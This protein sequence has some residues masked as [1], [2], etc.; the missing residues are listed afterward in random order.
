MASA[1]THICKWMLGLTVLASAGYGCAEKEP[2]PAPERA[3][4][5]PGYTDV[6]VRLKVRNP[7]AAYLTS[8]AAASA[9][10]PGAKTRSII[11]KGEG[12]YDL[13]FTA[14][15]HMI[16]SLTLIMMD[17]RPDGSEVFDFAQTVPTSDTDDIIPATFDLRG[18]KGIKRFYV[19]ANMT[20]LHIGAFT[21]NGTMIDLGDADD[22]H[23][24]AGRLMTVDHTSGEGSNILMTGTVSG[25]NGQ[26]DFDITELGDQFEMSMADDAI[27][28][29]VETPVSLTKAVSKVL[30]TCS[31]NSQDGKDFVNITDVKDQETGTDTYTGWLHLE[32]VR[33]ILNTLNLKTFAIYQEKTD[34]A[35]AY[36][37]DPNL[38]MGEMVEKRISTADGSWTYGPKNLENYLDNFVYYNTQSMVEM[39]TW[40]QEEDGSGTETYMDCR[41]RTATK[42]DE[43][44][45][46]VDSGNHYTEGLFCPEN[47]VHKDI[48]FTDEDE[49]SAANRLVSTHLVIGGKYV[50]KSIYILENEGQNDETLVL[51]TSSA[52]E[53]SAGLLKSDLNEDLGVT[54]EDGTFWYEIN[55]HEYYTYKAMEWKTRN[56]TKAVFARHDGGWGYW[57]SMIDGEKNA[58]D[59]ISNM[60]QEYWGLKRNH[61]Y[62]VNVKKIITPGASDPGN[63]AM[64]IH[65]ELIDWIDQGGEDID[66][67]VPQN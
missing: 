10:T 52:E 44:R 16:H 2:A 40:E 31:V 47:M 4:Q 20:Q 59:M 56:D 42:Y 46:G 67:T 61:Y 3:Q 35:G 38:D 53:E 33:Y 34:A 63:A 21:E 54:Y 51:Y 14:E 30:M 19:G 27:T 65:S 23:S 5:N 13:G 12:E 50:P 58:D 66:I 9:D 36:L 8:H 45:L 49:F 15:E 24:I 26:T 43:E 28:I 25:K 60:K 11:D 18:R 37:D 17:V 6:T 41:S 29:R 22:G 55:D 64:R 48:E 7:A 57:Y 39:L 62:I 1:I 32:N